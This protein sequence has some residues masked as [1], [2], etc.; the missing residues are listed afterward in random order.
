[1][2]A[3]DWRGEP[4]DLLVALHAKRSHA[5]IARI[6]RDAPQIPR[7][8]A[9]TGTDLY[10]ALDDADVRSSLALATRVVALQPHAR[11]PV[12]QARALVQSA[13]A[14]RPI[15]QPPFTACTLAHLRDVKDPLLAARAVVAAPGVRVVHLGDAD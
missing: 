4:C 12:P 9:L 14:A 8:V 15:A 3:G 10:C 11:E 13:S 5:A 6:A 7:I 2:L 1:A